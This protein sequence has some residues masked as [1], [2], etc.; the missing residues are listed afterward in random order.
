MLSLLI[1]LRYPY[2]SQDIYTYIIKTNRHVQIKDIKLNK[3]DTD[4][5]QTLTN[6]VSVQTTFGHIFKMIND[7]LH[8]RCTNNTQWVQCPQQASD[9]VQLCINM[10]LAQ[11]VHTLSLCYDLNLITFSCVEYKLLHCST[12][13]K[14]TYIDRLFTHRKYIIMTLTQ[15]WDK[16]P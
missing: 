6:Y 10:I 15:Y 16:P 12:L 11:S 2:M 13:N 14:G 7:R 4:T 9:I 1:Y 8:C 3:V 5:N